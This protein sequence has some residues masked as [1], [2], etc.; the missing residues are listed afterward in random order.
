MGSAAA[1]SSSATTGRI[2]SINPAT[3]VPLGDV[4]DMGADEV[5]AA[6]ARVRAA[7]PAW[8]ALPLKERCRRGA[9]VPHAGVARVDAGVAHQATERRQPALQARHQALAVAADTAR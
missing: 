8:A 5:R 3:G 7:Q 6:V 9:R 1:L 4:P 2:V